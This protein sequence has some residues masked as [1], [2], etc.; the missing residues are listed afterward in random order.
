MRILFS[1][2]LMVVSAAVLGQVSTAFTYQGEL[3]HDGN[4]ADGTFDFEFALYTQALDGV[5]FAGPTT[6]EDAVVSDGLFAVEIDFGAQVFGITDQWLEVRVRQ[7]G[8]SGGFTTLSP[9]QKITPAPLAMNAQSVE[10]DAVGTGQIADGSVGLADIDASQ[11]QARIDSVCTSFFEAVQGVEEDG[12]V[13]CRTFLNNLNVGLGLIGSANN[14][15]VSLSIDSTETQ[16][17]IAGFCPPGES[18]RAISES[19]AVTCEADSDAG[20]DITAVNV[21]AGLVGGAESG[22]VTIALDSASVWSRGGDTATT[23]DVIG[24][25]NDIRFRTV[26]NNRQ[27]SAWRHEL[28]S[29]RH[30]PVLIAGAEGNRALPDAK[31]AV[32]G[33]GGGDGTEFDCDIGRDEPCVNTVNEEYTTVS[34]GF[35]NYARQDYA[36]VG[37]GQKNIASG[38][39]ATVSGGSENEALVS[40]A[41]VGGGQGNV[42]GGVWST[43]AGGINNSATVGTAFVGGGSSNTASGIESMIVGGENNEAAGRLSFAS[44]TRAKAMHDGAFV[45]SDFEFSDFTSTAENQ[46]LIRASGNVGINTGNPLAVLHVEGDANEDLLRVR[47]SGSTKLMIHDNGG[48]T[49]GANFTPPENGLGVF[50]NITKGGGS[51]KIDHPLDPENKYLYHSFVESPDMMNIYNGNVTTDDFGQAVV[52]LPDWFDALNRDFRYQ[53]TCI[54]TFAQAIVREKIQGNRFTIATSE[55]NVEV[56]W[57]VTGIRHDPYAEKNRIAVEEDKPA[58]ERGKLLHPDAWD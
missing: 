27:V 8:Q 49:I 7:G 51:F 6:V 4:L 34:G 26:V 55:P 53:L 30:A 57:Q 29:G 24:T 45:W 28:D 19:G 50:G 41:T 10:F 23:S 58:S 13:I 12:S 16:R 33:G 32:I 15:L 21:G 18:I 5:V 31:A 37:G 44:G 1:T 54:G 20:G 39:N 46:F 40:G 48:T 22:D 52:E 11:V 38:F 17:R 43:V 36:T 2:L 14:G 42:A 35:G 25:T 3:V 9:R 56:S 47:A